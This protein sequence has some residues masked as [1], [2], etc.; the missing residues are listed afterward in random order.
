MAFSSL[1]YPENTPVVQIIQYV[2]GSHILV[3]PRTKLI[4]RRAS[5]AASLENLS[6]NRGKRREGAK[7]TDSRKEN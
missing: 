1:R 6:T 5:C 7:T 2:S 4:Q 3:K